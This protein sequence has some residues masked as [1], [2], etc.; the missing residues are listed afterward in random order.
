M[1]GTEAKPPID[2][3]KNNRPYDVCRPAFP[4]SVNKNQLAED[5]HKIGDHARN[6]AE[7]QI[8][9]HPKHVGRQL[10]GDH[11]PSALLL[12]NKK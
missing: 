8:V 2:Q 10:G 9:R 6:A 12:I 5:A 3:N 11:R 4:F 7:A 1:K